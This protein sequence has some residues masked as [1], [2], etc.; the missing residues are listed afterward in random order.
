[1]A[2]KVTT[3][4]TLVALVYLIVAA[5]PALALPIA[6]PTPNRAGSHDQRDI[7]ERDLFLRGL[8]SYFENLDRREPADRLLE[9]IEKRE[10]IEV[11]R[12]RLAID[13]KRGDIDTE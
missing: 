7:A 6:D 3:M 2:Q 12:S 8:G 10:T 5:S 4:K 13:F 11:P 9:L 1:M